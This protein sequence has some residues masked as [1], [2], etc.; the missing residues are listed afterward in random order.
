MTSALIL[1]G[2]GSGQDATRHL[3]PHLLSLSE[4]E[5]PSFVRI[6]D[7]PLLVPATDFFTCYADRTFRK[8]LKDGLAAGTVE[9]VQ[10]NLLIEG[11]RRSAFALPP[12]HGG[13]A[14]SF[15]YVF[16]FT[17]ELDHDTPDA[18]HLERTLRLAIALGATAAENKVG[19]YVRRISTCYRPAKDQKGKVGA[20]GVVAE[21]W[22]KLTHWHHEAV[23]ALTSFQALKLVFVRPALLYGAFVVTGVTP[24][25]AV[26][27]V[28]KYE[29]EKL[30]LLW[31][32]DLAQNSLH[33]EDF[34]SALYCAAKWAG[35]QPSREAIL[36]AHSELLAPASTLARDLDLPEQSV[37]FANRAVEAAVFC[38][39]DD[40]E[41]TQLDIAR[42]T[43]AVMGVR[44]GFQ[45]KLISSFAKLNLADVTSDVNE[46][47]LESWNQMLQASDPPVQPDMPVSPVIPADL[48]GPEVISF[49]N[50][51]LK[52]LTGWRPQHSLTVETAREMVDGFAKE[53]HWPAL[54]KA[55][56]KK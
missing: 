30:D 37:N 1:G 49:D 26:G 41:T 8:A 6:V 4:E 24:R 31:S 47:H 9:Y 11:T 10:G 32:Q 53:G 7:R 55:M 19:C 33:A 52:Q 12:G 38:A 50:T 2:L 34:A 40:G 44:I 29:G 35:S 54:R 45:G 51:A 25:L 36:Q 39:V 27:E 5:R 48:L 3:L 46:K 17:G 23:R 42:V 18:V 21:P 20:S 15:D 16:D 13:P 28:Y 14:K 43:E 22:G 56:P